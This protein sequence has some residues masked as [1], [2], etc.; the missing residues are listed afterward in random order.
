MAVVDGQHSSPSSGSV[1]DRAKLAKSKRF[2]FWPVGVALACA[3][4]GGGG[5]SVP[6]EHALGVC[7]GVSMPLLFDED[8]EDLVLVTI[9]MEAEEEGEYSY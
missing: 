5:D 2:L 3:C 9:S 6:D 7:G 1:A 4:G 8:D